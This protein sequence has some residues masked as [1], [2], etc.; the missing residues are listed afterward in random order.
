MGAI[1]VLAMA[2]DRPPAS[3]DS[4]KLSVNVVPGRFFTGVPELEAAA[5]GNAGDGADDVDAICK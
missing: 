5:S 2:P 3:N 1:E 4:P